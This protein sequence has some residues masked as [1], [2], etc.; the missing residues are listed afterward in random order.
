MYRFLIGCIFLAG[1][2]GALGQPI[3][4]C[5]WEVA[6][7]SDPDRV[8]PGRGSGEVDTRRA[9]AACEAAV[10][11]HPDVARFHYQLGR[12]LVYEADRTG[13]DRAPGFPPLEKAAAMGHTQAQFVLGLM[14]K[15]R[16]EACAA[17]PLTLAAA[18]SG[19]KAARIAYVNDAL[20]GTLDDCGDVADHARLQ[21]FLSAAREQVEGYYENMLLDALQRQLDAAAR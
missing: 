8:G 21:A 6:H 18:E 14:H 4:A 15:R 10:A 2:T 3:D 17:A 1:A 12:A 20:A 5:D 16:G 19:L 11:A 9:I 7:P 13:G